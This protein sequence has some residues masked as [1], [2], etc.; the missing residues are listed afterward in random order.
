MGHVKSLNADRNVQILMERLKIREVSGGRTRI[1]KWLSL[2]NR[3]MKLCS[4]PRAK[5]REG[6]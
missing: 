4:S 3:K 5:T 1:I 2:W 6:L